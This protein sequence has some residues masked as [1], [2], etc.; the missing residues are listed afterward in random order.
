MMVMG[1]GPFG[2]LYAGAFADRIGAPATIAVGGII[3]LAAG[4]LFRLQLPAIRGEGRALLEAQ[5]HTA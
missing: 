3:C 4:I 5:G 1:L 2:A